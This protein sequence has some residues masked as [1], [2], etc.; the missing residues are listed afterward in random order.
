MS[1]TSRQGF[2][3]HLAVALIAVALPV[4]PVRRTVRCGSIPAQ[5][6]G[7]GGIATGWRRFVQRSR[8][9][10]Y[11]RFA[12]AGQA[13]PVRRLV[14]HVPFQFFGGKNPHPNWLVGGVPSAINLND[15]GAGGAINMERLNLV[16]D[17]IDRAY[18]FTEQVYIPD[19]PA[20]ASFNKGW[21][22]GGGLSGQAMMSYGDIPD[23]ANDYT[24]ANLVLP[25]GAITGGDLGK[26][27]AVDLKDPDQI[28]EFVSHSWY[29]YADESKGLHPWDGV[30]EPKARP[31]RSRHHGA[32]KELAGGPAFGATAHAASSG[33]VSRVAISQALEDFPGDAGQGLGGVAPARLAR[34]AQMCQPRRPCS[35]GLHYSRGIGRQVTVARRL[36]RHPDS[37]RP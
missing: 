4:N 1:T 18:E 7:P 11:W 2:R 33:T 9:P 17:I 24:A 31:C 34:G 23:R 5:S 27:Q 32:G 35:A 36:A 13:S 30:T 3:R 29:K 26:V 37:S 21:L 12:R 16:K 10:Q 22:Y 20:I 6:I 14:C 15:V 25:R 28:Q 8:E 19:L